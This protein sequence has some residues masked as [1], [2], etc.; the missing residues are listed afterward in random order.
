MSTT[1]TRCS[2][3]SKSMA[4]RDGEPSIP[5]RHLVACAVHAAAM[6][7]RPSSST[8]NARESY[9]HRAAGGTYSP[10]DL[11]LGERLLV[12]LGFVIDEEGRLR[13]TAQ[14]EALLDGTLDDAA[15]ALGMR[16]LELGATRDDM[17]LLE[18]VPD[19]GRREELLVALGRRFDDALRRTYGA[20]GE[21]LVV[22]YARSELDGLGYPELARAV[23][24]VSLETDQ[25][26]YDVSAPRLAGSPRLFEVKAT[27][28]E[29]ATSVEVHLTR[30]EART[31]L[32]LP[33]WSLVVCW[34][35]DVQRRTGEVLGWID[36]AKLEERFPRDVHF[37]RW[38][39]A[40]IEIQLAEL[41]PGI[42]AAAG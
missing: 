38:E 26:G 17:R 11:Q 31:G 40:A 36:A 8:M 29:V 32:R 3:T 2:I 16:A 14:L 4:D 23:R 15:A 28:R 27:G 1:S 33:G 20:I 9:W 6:L 18:I 22:A 13:P 12:D 41:V 7:D 19:P 37:G 42:P 30:N 39:S 25:A 10:S 34:V 5:S 21:E 35:D 24:H